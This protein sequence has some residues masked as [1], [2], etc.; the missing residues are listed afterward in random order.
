MSDFFPKVRFLKNISLLAKMTV[1]KKWSYSKR[2]EKN[3][4]RFKEAVFFTTMRI[5][6]LQ[7]VKSAIFVV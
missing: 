7:S 1:F 5:P 6:L 4:I 3:K 2:L